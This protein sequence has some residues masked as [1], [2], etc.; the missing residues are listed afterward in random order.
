MNTAPPELPQASPPLS[1]KVF[2]ACGTP[3]SAR[4]SLAALDHVERNLSGGVQF[5]A[6]VWRFDRV[7][8]PEGAPEARAEATDAD[9]LLVALDRSAPLPAEMLKWL[10]DWAEHSR[11]NDS[12]LGVVTVGAAAKNAEPVQIGALKSLARRYGLELIM[13]LEEVSS[14]DGMERFKCE[15]WESPTKARKPR[16]RAARQR[17]RL[18]DSR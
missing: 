3:D 11:A 17:I 8:A 4:A 16:R 10:G 14:G 15:S 1:M 9:L 5:D 2:V 7:T 18:P 12:A 6:K 13:R